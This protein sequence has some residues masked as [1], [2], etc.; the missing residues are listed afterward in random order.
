MTISQGQ[1]YLIPGS[2]FG[3]GCLVFIMPRGPFI[4]QA[5]AGLLFFQSPIFIDEM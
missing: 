4:I 3:F 1:A 5:E 2:D